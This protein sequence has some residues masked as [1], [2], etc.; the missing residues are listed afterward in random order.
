[1]FAADFT[2]KTSSMNL[3]HLKKAGSLTAVWCWAI[4]WTMESTNYISREHEMVRMG[5]RMAMRMRTIHH[6]QSPPSVHAPYT[7]VTLVV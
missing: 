2:M 4:T 1:M 5:L 3:C 7:I 6:P